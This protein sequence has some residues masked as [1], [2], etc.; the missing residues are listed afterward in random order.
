MDLNNFDQYYKFIDKK[1]EGFGLVA[2]PISSW[3]KSQLYL[4]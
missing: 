2:L 4:L 3:K 1:S